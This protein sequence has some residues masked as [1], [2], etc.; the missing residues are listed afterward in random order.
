[1]SNKGQR[2]GN[3]NQKNNGNKNKRNNKFWVLIGNYPPLFSDDPDGVIRAIAN[4]VRRITGNE[5]SYERGSVFSSMEFALSFPTEQQMEAVLGLNGSFIYNNPIWIIKYPQYY[6]NIGF[7]L[8]KIFAT[9]TCNGQVDLNNLKQRFEQLGKNPSDI[10]FNNRDF[11]EF[12]LY[13][14]GTESRD[15]RFYV[16]TLILTNNFIEDINRWSPFL[17]FL[18]TLH[19]LILNQNPL[20]QQPDLP[21]YPYISIDCDPKIPKGNKKQIPWGKDQKQKK[22]KQNRNPWTDDNDQDQYQGQNQDL[23]HQNSNQNQN[24]WNTKSIWDNDDDDE[25]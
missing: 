1:M 23:W 4:Q 15:K 5:L 11:V 24:R 25:D 16:D 8:S 6:E 14:L 19:S 13:R 20:K 12:L 18:P 22:G 9:S 21:A 7:D 17:V 3:S 2:W 10:D